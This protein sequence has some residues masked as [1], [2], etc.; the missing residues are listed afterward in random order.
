SADRAKR[1]KRDPH[2]RPPSALVTGHR[3][4]SWP[5]SACR[6]ALGAAR[7]LPGGPSMLMGYRT[8]ASAWKTRRHPPPRGSLLRERQ[9]VGRPE[10]A[11]AAT[12]G[13]SGWHRAA[14][15]GG[16]SRITTGSST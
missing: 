10:R 15:A 2:L 7:H 9:R 12:Q 3:L 5:P 6:P 4:T 11:G 8:P 16:Q 1:S 14:V 13:G